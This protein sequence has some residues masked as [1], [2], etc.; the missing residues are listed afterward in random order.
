M[1]L[2]PIDPRRLD[3][4]AFA[5][6]AG[7]LAGEVS[8][9]DF[10]RLGE[11]LMAGT[12]L[13][14]HVMWRAEGA[15]RRDRAGRERAQL[16]L[17]AETEVPMQCQRCLAPLHQPLAVD[18]PFAFAASEDEAAQLDEDCDEDMLVLSRS[19]DLID[20]L[21][22]ELLLALPLVPRHDSCPEP[23]PALPAV[24]ASDEEVARENPFRALEVLRRSG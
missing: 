12:D 14:G 24:M 15:W 18:R 11:L 6:A 8:L 20:L 22:D 3:V 5:R 9:R 1:K 13:A 17:L 16:R 21:E 10:S 2:K 7:S 19:F 4:E 23:L